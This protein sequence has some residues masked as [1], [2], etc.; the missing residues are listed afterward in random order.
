MLPGTIFLMLRDPGDAETARA[1]VRLAEICDLLEETSAV[2]EKYIN[3]V[4]EAVALL[5]ERGEAGC[6]L[7][8][9][10]AFFT[11]SDE[12]M[13]AA[14]C[15]LRETFEKMKIASIDDAVRRLRFVKKAKEYIESII[16]FFAN[17]HAVL[18]A[19]SRSGWWGAK[20]RVCEIRLHVSVAKSQGDA[21]GLR[22]LVCPRLSVLKSW[23]SIT[24]ERELEEDEV[25]DEDV[26]FERTIVENAARHLVGNLCE[27]DSGAA[28]RAARELGLGIAD[29]TLKKWDR[30]DVRIRTRMREQNCGDEDEHP[31]HKVSR[32]DKEALI[33]TLFEEEAGAQPLIPMI[34]IG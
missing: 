22:V 2:S 7:L 15:L 25:D 6:K 19:H 23:V 34:Q 16:V 12:P 20:E 21:F 4:F 17:E 27:R 29:N 5:R 1:N 33:T 8:G 3:E 28:A 14:A 11:A 10:L 32:G 31:I 26:E 13:I 30:I 18:C 24:A 9:T